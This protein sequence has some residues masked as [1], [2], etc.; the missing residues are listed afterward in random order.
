MITG[1]AG[2]I[3]CHTASYFAKKGHEIVI[4]DNLSRKGSLDNLNWLKKQH[5]ITHYK[6]NIQDEKAVEDVFRKE[7]TIGAVIHLAAQVAVTTSV[8]NPRDDFDINAL[9]TLN[10]LQAVRHFCPQAPFINASTNKVYGLLHNV[11]I[12]EGLKRY[13]I[14]K[15]GG[16]N[17][18]EPLDFHSPYGCSKGSADQYVIDYARIYD[19]K[20]VSVRQSCIYGERQFGVEDQ[21]WLAWFI[22]AT[23][24]GKKISIYGDGKQ[25]RDVL[26]VQDLVELYEKFIEQGS[27]L[28]GKAYNVGGG[29]KFS[30]SL[31][32]FIDILKDQGLE[33]SY[34]FGD[35]RPGDQKVFVSDNTKVIKELGWE[36][37]TAPVQGIQT[38]VSWVK[39]NKDLLKSFMAN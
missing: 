15:K 4:I 31:L 17:E 12:L 14:E 29:L 13:E 32:E 16:I 2:F 38:I 21:G 3:G 23:V 35:W 8:S 19:L 25:V 6:T 11:K 33:I 18:S 20:T 30:L 9:G 5:P 1:G 26:Y 22:I 36:P 10:M 39:Q 7:N 37:K 27:N 34:T 24:L 28:N